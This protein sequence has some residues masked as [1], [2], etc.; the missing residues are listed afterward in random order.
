MCDT[1]QN[2]FPLGDTVFCEAKLRIFGPQGLG[3][4]KMLKGVKK[5]G[6]PGSFT[7]HLIST[8]MILLG[9]HPTCGRIRLSEYTYRIMEDLQA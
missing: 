6:S 8:L 9:A 5:T 2:V 4:K 1:G 3:F 7:S